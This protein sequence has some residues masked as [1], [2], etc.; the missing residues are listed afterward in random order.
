[1][2]RDVTAVK[3]F[4]QIRGLTRCAFHGGGGGGSSLFIRVNGTFSIA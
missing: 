4:V 2:G 1:M 3:A